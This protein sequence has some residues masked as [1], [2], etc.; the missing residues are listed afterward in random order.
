MT[1]S[2]EASVPSPTRLPRGQLVFVCVLMLVGVGF[3]GLAAYRAFNPPLAKAEPDLAAEAEK[4]LEKR[5]FKPLSESLEKLVNDPTYKPIPTQ[6]PLL[7]D[8]QTPDFTLDDV[9]GK[10]WSLAK[11]QA[12][13][14]VVLV[15]YYGY[16]CDHCVG[17]LKALNQDIAK[18][19]ELGATV[20]AV[21]PDTAEWTKT[22]RSGQQGGPA[23][24]RLP[25]RSEGRRG[26]PDARHVRHRPQGQGR[27]DQRR[28]RA[29]HRGPH[30][31]GR[32]RQGRGA[33]RG[34]VS[35]LDWGGSP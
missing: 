1:T 2:P 29:V 35:Q 28:R 14:P 34:E 22:L 5:G 30:A 24:R 3:L 11:T 18:F 32:D 6:A 13:G 7:L 9:G 12:E 16:T 4:Y 17:Q 15:F 31:S 33:D 10:P 20:V 25:A 8:Q 19:R 26:R 27:L 23:L 21:S